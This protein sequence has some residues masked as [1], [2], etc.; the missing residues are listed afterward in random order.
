M[1]GNDPH[2]RLIILTYTFSVSLAFSLSA[3]VPVLLFL[4]W[5]F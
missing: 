4:H 1:N 5:L 3:F 2:T